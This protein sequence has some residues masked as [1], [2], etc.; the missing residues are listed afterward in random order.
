MPSSKP[1]PINGNPAA[2]AFDRAVDE[3]RRGRAIQVADGSRG[4]VVAAIE[5]VQESLL[6]RLLTA[7]NGGATVFV[8]GERAQAA[9]RAGILRDYR[10]RV[11]EVTRDYG[12]TDRSDAPD[13]SQAIHDKQA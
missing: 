13:D 5:T 6:A 7:N 11:A 2:L 4:V 12:M 8:T 10:L 1:S 3:L 9:G